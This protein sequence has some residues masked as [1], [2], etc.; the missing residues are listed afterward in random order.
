MLWV[1]ALSSGIEAKADLR[2]VEAYGR[3]IQMIFTENVGQLSDEVVFYSMHPTT[4]Y[5]L[6]DGSIHINGVRLSFGARPKFVTGDMPLKTRISYFGRGKAISNVPTYKRVVLKEVYPKIDVILTADG[7]GVVEFQ[8]IVYPG[9][10]PS[11][12]KVEADGEVK[13]KKGGIYVVKD[14]EEVVRIS[15]LKAYQGVRLKTGTESTLSL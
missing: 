9:G 8:F 13:V 7:R 11:Q 2:A 5:V 4:V 3:G 14:G 10:D 6:K 15:G 12:I 1:M